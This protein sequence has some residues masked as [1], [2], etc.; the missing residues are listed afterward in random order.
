[1]VFTAKKK[2]GSVILQTSCVSL[3][4]KR[5]AG[6]HR[7]NAFCIIQECC[8]VVISCFCFNLVC[9]TRLSF[10]GGCYIG[11]GVLECFVI[12]NCFAAISTSN[13]LGC[14]ELSKD[15]LSFVLRCVMSC[16]VLLYCVVL[17]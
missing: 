1:M 13:Q 12:E 7:A 11:F 2:A 10:I 16:S 3:P 15:L 17:S 4:R 9:V 8:S 14:I 5:I 6:K